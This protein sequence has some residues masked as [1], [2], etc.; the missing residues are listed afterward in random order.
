[1]ELLQLKYFKKVAEVGKICDAAEALFISAPALSAAVSR[2]EKDLGMPLFD[3]SNNRITLNQQGQI[4]LQGVDRIFATLENTREEMSRSLEAQ[5]EQTLSLC[6]ISSTQWVEL[7]TSY[8]QRYPEVQLSCV[9]MSRGNLELGGLPAQYDF[10]L[11]VREDVPAALSEELEQLELMEDQ[12][13]IMVNSRHP[14]AQ[15]DSV[16]IGELK[17]EVLFFPMHTYPVSRFLKEMFQNAQMPFPSE[18]TLSHLTA[19]QMAAKG[20]GIGFSSIHTVRTLSPELCYVPISTPHSPWKLC[21]YWRKGA[22]WSHGAKSF[23]RFVKEYC[24]AK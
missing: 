8:S 16:E 20:I 21:L 18:N 11:A 24:G 5:T 17:D 22:Q 1:M 13:V 9:D 7:V 6:M 19:Q 3:R 23:V 4:F 12:P 2:L 14:L 15:K 10:L